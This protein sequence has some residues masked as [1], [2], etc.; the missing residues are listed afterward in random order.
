MSRLASPTIEQHV[1]TILGDR[2]RDDGTGTREDGTGT[3][4]M[5]PLVPV[6]ELLF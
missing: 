1:T 6:P 3:R 5:N 4:G 2:Y